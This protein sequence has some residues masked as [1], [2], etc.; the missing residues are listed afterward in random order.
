MQFK[1]NRNSNKIVFVIFIIKDSLFFKN[2]KN[3]CLILKKYLKINIFNI[4][5]TF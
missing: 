2:I 5:L 4:C 3:T 1:N